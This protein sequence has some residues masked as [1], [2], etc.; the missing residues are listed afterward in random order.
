METIH[1]VNEARPGDW[2]R[3]THTDGRSVGMTLVR[4]T[5]TKLIVM[6]RAGTSL[7]VSGP[8]IVKAVG[9]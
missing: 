5:P 1:N 9:R 6:D 4:I 8:A 3:I 7:V 2:V